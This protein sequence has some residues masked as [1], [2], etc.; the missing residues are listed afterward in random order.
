MTYHD[1]SFPP[2][3]TSESY[4]MIVSPT[5]R[6]PCWNSSVTSLYLTW[7]W[8]EHGGSC[9]LG[10]GARTGHDMTLPP[11]CKSESCIIII[12]ATHLMS[13]SKPSITS[14]YCTYLWCRND[15]P[16]VL[17]VGARTGHNM[18]FPPTCTSKNYPIIIN[19]TH[20][21]LWS[22]FSITSQYWT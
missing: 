2:R 3:C 17:G 18:S 15:T 8:C 14:Q 10:V 19:A 4:P 13:C 5:Q 16:D 9:Y 7:L 1:M 20:L 12:S 22:N 6:M 21:M 11:R